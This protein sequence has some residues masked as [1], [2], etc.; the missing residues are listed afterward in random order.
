MKGRWAKKGFKIGVLALVG[1]GVFGLV[2]MGLW[3]WLMPALFGVRSVTFLQALGL[4]ALSRVLFGGFRGHRGGHW[5]EGFRRFERMT[6]E[7]RERLRD[8]WRGRAEEGAAPAAP[9]A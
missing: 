9:K 8:A 2:V 5:G 1:V 7:E 4:L 3:N 6:P